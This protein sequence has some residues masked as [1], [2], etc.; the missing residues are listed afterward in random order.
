MKKLLYLGLVASPSIFAQSLTPEVLST[1]GT[2][3]T[4][5]THQ[6]EFTIGEVATST[7]T[8]GGN[9]LTQGFH[10]PE[11]RFAS[12][13]DFS[14]DVVMNLYPNPT[15]QFVTIET[16]S[17][18]ELKVIVFDMNGKVVL[19]SNPFIQKQVFDLSLLSAGNYI[20]KVMTSAGAPI[21]NYSLI[22]KSNS[23]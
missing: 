4:N 11:L 9:T 6:I 19:T 12:I 14:N 7:L 2:T 21:E 3:F 16:T 17:E 8:A 1:S 13:E 18:M 20:F 5:A 22:K 15:E 10:Q 23:N